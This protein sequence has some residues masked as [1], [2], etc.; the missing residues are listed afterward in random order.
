M[1]Y[2]DFQNVFGYGRI[3]QIYI[4]F[5]DYMIQIC[6]I[7]R[8]LFESANQSTSFPLALIALLVS[9]VSVSPPLC[10]WQSYAHVSWCTDAYVKYT[11]IFVY[12]GIHAAR[13]FVRMCNSNSGMLQYSSETLRKIVVNCSIA[14]KRVVRKALFST[15][16]W[17]R[18]YKHPVHAATVRGDV[19]IT[20]NPTMKPLVKIGLMNARSV[21]N[22]IDYVFDSIIDN[23]LDLVALTETWL[24]NE[25]VTN[26]R[27]LSVLLFGTYRSN[28]AVI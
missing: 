23:N 14:P 6:S 4:I 11:C 10:V 9:T 25:E 21:G 28:I 19:V 12:R 26:R 5:L 24:S 7:W 22:K 20:I 3:S 18:R 1:N 15:R 27:N 8:R 16:I 17:S 2:F 13:Y